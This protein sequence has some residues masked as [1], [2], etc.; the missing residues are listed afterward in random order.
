MNSERET[1]LAVA[2][3]EEWQWWI[4]TAMLDPDKACSMFCFVYGEDCHK[5]GLRCWD[6]SQN[7]LHMTLGSRGDRVLAEYDQ[8][9]RV[10]I[11]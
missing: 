3:P 2:E 5:C 8:L 4:V 6:Y 7:P 1:L 11:V 10:G 9:K